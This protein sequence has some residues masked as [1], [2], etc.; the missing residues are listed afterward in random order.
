MKTLLLCLLLF[1]GSAFAQM[2]MTLNWSSVQGVAGYFITYELNGASK[3]IQLTDPNRTMVVIPLTVQGTYKWLIECYCSD[4][5]YCKSFKTGTLMV[6]DNSPVEDLKA[7]ATQTAGGGVPIDPCTIDC[8]I[9][10]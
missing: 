5:T 2:E 4:N 1:S 10:P 3:R 7:T 9:D 8:V 6:I